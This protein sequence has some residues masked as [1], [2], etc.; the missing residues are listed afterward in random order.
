MKAQTIIILIV[1]AIIFGVLFFKRDAIIDKIIPPVEPS[2]NEESE[3][4]VYDDNFPLHEGS[5]GE[6]VKRLQK[7]VNKKTNAGLNED[8]SWGAKTNSAFRKVGIP[9]IVPE[10]FYNNF[11]KKYEN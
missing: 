11:V 10:T 1:V 8:G 7:I 5:K 3:N 6:K 9:A 4:K 2:E